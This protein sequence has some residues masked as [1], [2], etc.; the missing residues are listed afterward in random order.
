MQR[1]RERERERETIKNVACVSK[2]MEI[3]AKES[4]PDV[5]QED[6]AHSL[7]ALITVVAGVQS[8]RNE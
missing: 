8:R 7:S 2:L 6:K 1:E 5:P 4:P 3:S